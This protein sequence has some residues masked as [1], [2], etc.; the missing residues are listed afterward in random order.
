MRKTYET[1]VS[2]TCKDLQKHAAPNAVHDAIKASVRQY[3]LTASISFEWEWLVDASAFRFIVYEDS[4]W[5]VT[6]CPSLFAHLG[7]W[8]RSG[9]KP[10]PRDVVAMLAGL[11][12]IEEQTAPSWTYVGTEALSRPPLEP[13]FDSVFNEIFGGMKDF[14]KRR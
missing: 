6:E 3:G 8:S 5:M 14:G 10:S 12:F 13:T 1:R 7:A 9:F 4:G 2:N 11:G